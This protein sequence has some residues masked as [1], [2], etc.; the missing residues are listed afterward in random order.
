MNSFNL[1]LGMSQAFQA[2][3]VP[4][5]TEGTPAVIFPGLNNMDEATL[6]LFKNTH[7]AEGVARLFKLWPGP[8]AKNY[9]VWSFYFDK[10]LEGPTIRADIDTMAAVYPEDFLPMG[11][12]RTSDGHEVGASYS[13][14]EGEEPVFLQ[15]GWW[16][17]PAQVV[18]FMPD[19][20]N[21]DEPPTYSPAT[22]PTDV[23]VLMGQAPRDFTSFYTVEGLLAYLTAQGWGIEV[24]GDAFIETSTDTHWHMDEARTG[25][26]DGSLLL[27]LL[28][29]IARYFGRT[30]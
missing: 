24:A 19:V 20:W 23:N 2:E 9:R 1:W 14:I 8:G 30:V 13:D 26:Y 21:G 27:A 16:P 12:W 10:P 28:T 17:V 3:L 15:P 22:V 5:I 7:D 11:A 25:V 29:D 4:L 6:A 18:N